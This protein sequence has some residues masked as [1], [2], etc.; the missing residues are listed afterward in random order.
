[1]KQIIESKG[2]KMIPY[3]S[4]NQQ[5]AEGAVTITKMEWYQR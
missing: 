4:T 3:A 1:M 2:G 5:K